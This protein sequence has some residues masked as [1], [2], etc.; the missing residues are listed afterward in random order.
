MRAKRKK[1]KRSRVKF[2]QSKIK[3]EQ[4]LRAEATK[5]VALYRNMSGNGGVGSCRKGKKR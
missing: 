3:S 1:M 4:L 2:L 5:K